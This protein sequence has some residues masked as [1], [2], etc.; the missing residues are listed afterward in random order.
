MR[1]QTTCPLICVNRND[2]IVVASEDIEEVFAE[3]SV[4]ID[5]LMEWGMG[6]SDAIGAGCSLEDALTRAAG[7]LGSM[8]WVANSAY[9][10]QAAAGVGELHGDLPEE[11]LGYVSPGKGMPDDFTRNWSRHRSDGLVGYAIMTGRALAAADLFAALIGIRNAEQ[12]RQSELA[13][14]SV[15]YAA[16]QALVYRRCEIVVGRVE[17]LAFVEPLVLG[18][19]NRSQHGIVIGLRDRTELNRAFVELLSLSRVLGCRIEDLLENPTV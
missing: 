19:F 18:F 10:V 1:R 17:L 5:E 15:I 13:G 4:C 8:V 11:L 3:A 6:V 2:F 16:E 12:F 7:L 14:D 9:V